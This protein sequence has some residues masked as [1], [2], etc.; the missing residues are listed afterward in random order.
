MVF[1]RV[2]PAYFADVDAQR[3]AEL[4][5][6]EAEA[7]AAKVKLARA[8]PALVARVLAEVGESFANYRLVAG[9]EAELAARLA[10]GADL[11]VSVPHLSHDV[12][13][14][15]GLLELGSSLWDGSG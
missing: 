2:L 4:L 5:A 6:R 3:S 9:R 10:R 1:N 12:T 14:L 11:T 8:D 7:T 15:G 13:D